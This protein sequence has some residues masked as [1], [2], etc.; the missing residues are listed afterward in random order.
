MLD[1]IECLRLER[2]F[3]LCLT[4]TSFLPQKLHQSSRIHSF[5][6]TLVY[7]R[8]RLVKDSRDIR[9]KVVYIYKV[10]IYNVSRHFLGSQPIQALLFHPVLDYMQI[11][12]RIIS[13]HINCSN[14]GYFEQHNTVSENYYLDQLLFCP[15]FL[16]L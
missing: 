9:Q 3:I 12:K 8:F 11:W 4:R 1:K 5:Y 13:Q 16:I 7:K 2:I 6:I 10:C 14:H 15:F